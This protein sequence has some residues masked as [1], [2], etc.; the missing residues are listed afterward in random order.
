MKINYPFSAFFRGTT[1]LYCTRAK[2]YLLI[3]FFYHIL[4]WNIYFPCIEPFFSVMY[5]R[6]WASLSST[7]KSVLFHFIQP[8]V[9]FHI[10]TSYLICI[11]NEVTGFLKKWSIWLK[12]INRTFA[13]SW[14]RSQS[15]RKQ[16]I[17]LQS[18]SLDWFLYNRDLRH[19]REH[20]FEMNKAWTNVDHS[21][22]TCAKFSAKLTFLTPWYART[23]T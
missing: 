2:F 8:S 7:L 18:K 12:W 21:C 13:L 11:P 17:D 10:E 1:F 9:V 20:I 4:T 22:S 19:E 5:N 23:R 16:S 3:V 15:Y 6:V 14:R